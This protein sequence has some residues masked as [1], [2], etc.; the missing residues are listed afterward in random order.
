[1]PT[2]EYLCQRCGQ[3]FE[4]KMTIEV[5][6]KAKIKCPHCGSEDVEQQLFGV[7]FGGMKTGSG[8]ASGGCCDDSGGT[9]CCG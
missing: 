4:K 7:N 5:K 8:M 9:S 6:K 1:M 3:V 2:Y